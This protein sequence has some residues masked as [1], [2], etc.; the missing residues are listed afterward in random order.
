MTAMHKGE[1]E[2]KTMQTITAF[3]RAVKKSKKEKV[4]LSRL[5][6][7]ILAQGPC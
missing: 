2:K 4:I 6:R 7:V 1:K 3:V 5:M